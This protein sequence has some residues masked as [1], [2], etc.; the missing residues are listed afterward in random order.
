MFDSIRSQLHNVKAAGAGFTAR[1]PAHDDKKN[2]LSFTPMPDKALIH[3]HVGC[4]TDAVCAAI[5]IEPKDLFAKTENGNAYSIPKRI[6]AV[7]PYTDEE[8]RLLYENVRYE[9]KAFAQRHYESGQAIW[10]LN[11]ARRV[12][13]RLP[14]LLRAVSEGREIWLCEGEKDA[15]NLRGL[16]FAASTF[17]NW[18][19]EFNSFVKGAGI[20]LSRDHDKGGVAQAEDA[21]RILSEAAQS[22]KIVDLFD[23]EPLPDKHGRDISDWIESFPETPAEEIAEN[24]S[25]IAEGAPYWQRSA[26]AAKKPLSKFLFTPLDAFLEEP[27]E[28]TSYIWSDTLITGGFSI[29]SAKPKVGKSTVARSLAIKMV[30]GDLFLGRPTT[31][32]RI[33]YLCLEEKRGEV[34]KHFQKMG[35]SSGE[36]LIHTGTTPENALEE[37]WIAI[38]ELNPSLVI[39]DPLSRVLRV[40]DFND[41]GGMARGLEPFIDLARKTGCHILALHHDSKMERSGGDA[42]LGSTALFGAV[43][44]HIQ[45]K[46]RDKG[47]TIMTTQRTGEDMPETV[48]ELDNETGIINSHGDLQS[49]ILHE[50]REAVFESIK[51]GEEVG[52]QEIKDRV[53][54]FSSHGV[55]SKALREL[56][57]ENRVRRSGLG[58]RGDP[59]VYSRVF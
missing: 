10:G 44:C 45:L 22:I 34:R 31:K 42:L 21:A 19:P 37:L 12:P 39:I 36:I 32:G 55:I 29:C 26:A 38:A 27:Q 41:Y 15:D 59:Y 17:K 25:I 3:C 8:G 57:D 5:G 43:D 20:C 51:D 4:S 50:A 53:E 11:G 28:E 54:G 47:R 6:A 16:G 33:L 9:P 13:Y 14:E 23:A 49:F 46:K 56:V 1:C 52:E 35:V 24:L 58:K 18:K 7:Y 48:I 2:S 30:S 40:K